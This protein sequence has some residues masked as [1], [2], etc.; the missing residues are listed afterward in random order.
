MTTFRFDP[1][2][3]PP[4]CEALR[5]EVRGFVA[6]ELAAGAWMPKGDFGTHRSADFSRHLAARG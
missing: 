4:E 3:L 2:E 5:R 6:A 1:V